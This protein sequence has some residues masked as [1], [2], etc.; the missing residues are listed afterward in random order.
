MNRVFHVLNKKGNPS[1]TKQL[2]AVNLLITMTA[3]WNLTIKK[4][5]KGLISVMFGAKSEE[6]YNVVKV[7]LD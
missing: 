6:Y 2:S 4:L 1:R 7:N 3:T 5:K